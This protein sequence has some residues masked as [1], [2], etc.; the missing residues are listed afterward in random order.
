LSL[1]VRNSL[2]L[3]D[4]S[5]QYFNTYGFIP[6][7]AMYPTFVHTDNNFS[8]ELKARLQGAKSGWVFDTVGELDS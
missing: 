2:A 6:Q 7:S 4:T 3:A 5:D 8:N 1:P